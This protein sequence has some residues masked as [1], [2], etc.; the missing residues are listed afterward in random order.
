M[1]TQFQHGY[2]LLIG[3]D[4]NFLPELALPTVSKDLS[5]LHEVLT[6]PDR[7]AYDEAHVKL[8]TGATATRQAIIDGLEWLGTSLQQDSSDNAT[9]LVYFSG[10]GLRDSS[11][12]SE[13]FYLVPYDVRRNGIR[14]RSFRAIDFVDQIQ[15]LHPKRLLVVLDCCHATGFGVKGIDLGLEGYTA[16]APP[17]DLLT[18]GLAITDSAQAK[19]LTALQQGAGRAILTSSQG[20]QQSYTR[21]DET[22]SIFT[23][24]LI[25]ALTGHAQP[26][27][28]A[29]EVLVSDI[30]SHVHRRVPTSARTDHQVEQQPDYQ[31]SGNFPVA[32]LL[33]GKGV[34][35]GEAAPDPLLSPNAE[36]APLRAATNT[37]SGAIAQGRGAV[38]AG[39][40]GVAI[41]GNV[42]KS[43]IV[44]GDGNQ[45]EQVDTGGGTYVRGNVNL[46][47]G[48]FVG[49]DRNQSTIQQNSGIAFPNA[50]T[51]TGNNFNFHIGQ[52]VSFPREVTPRT[53]REP[54][55]LDVATPDK[56]EVNR[57]FFLAIAIKQPTSPPLQIADLPNV[58]SQDGAIFRSA[59]GAVIRYRVNLIA[60]DFELPQS[61][62]LFLLQSGADSVPRYFQ[63]K[64]RREGDLPILIDAYQVGEEDELAA[65]TR[66]T[67]KVTVAVADNVPNTPSAQPSAARPDPLWAPL[68]A[69][70]QV[71]PP[72]QR[73][74]AIATI[75]ALQSETSRGASADD[76]RLARQIEQLMVLL[77][78]TAPLIVFTFSRPTLTP[79]IGPAT[80]Y[81]L[82]KL[83]E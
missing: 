3:V 24:H 63:L 18:K 23:Y 19:G 12:G 35:K 11:G 59:D 76:R 69:L 55:R 20:T 31:L 7:C 37:G 56:V 27:E 16:A 10:H 28:G 30:V 33:G 34:S 58:N 83:T 52:P 6:H 15:G 32:L 67:I 25:E 80:A 53:Q 14:T 64:P 68:L 29:S 75:Q 26:V 42:A 73:D 82:E 36:R 40:R 8:I 45:V 22:M 38:A 60:P 44:T 79:I 51:V 1:P 71:A 2:A 41:G 43:V 17:L 77:P 57:F 21:Q 49:R 4:Q 9:A 65:Q 46:E 74:Q 66:I 48:D 72:V 61:S 39:E 70:A 81:V 54:I 62:Y 47:S 5:A 78:D 50:G 13:A